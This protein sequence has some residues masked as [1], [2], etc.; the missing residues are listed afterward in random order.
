N[1]RLEAVSEVI[2]LL[3]WLLLPIAL[4]FIASK[5]ITPMYFDRYVIAASPA[6]YLLVAKGLSNLK[7]KWV[8]YPLLLAIVL[9]ATPNLVNY[10]TQ[11]QRQQWR[12]TAELVELNTQEN[13]VLLFCPRMRY[14]PFPY[15]YQGE[16]DEFAIE[17]NVEDTEEIAALVNEAISKKERLWLIIRNPP[18]QRLPTE[19]YLIERYGD[20]SVI[21]ERHF[22]LIRVLLFDLS[23]VEGE[24][25]Q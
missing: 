3:L 12:E 24:E 15:Y 21:M 16:L 6:F 20:D 23:E 5:I 8:I 19:K 11:Y 25:A 1:I 17:Q 9:L 14:C 4:L 13:D 18:P 2:L 10:Y 22:T 7:V